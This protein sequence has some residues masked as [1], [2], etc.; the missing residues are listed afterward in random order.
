MAADLRLRKFVAEEQKEQLLRL[1]SRL[2]K[3]QWI[4]D[5]VNEI[6]KRMERIDR[7]CKQF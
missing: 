3:E 1:E 4:H 2:E 5:T 6:R 7:L